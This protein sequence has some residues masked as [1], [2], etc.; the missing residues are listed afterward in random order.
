[1]VRTD[2]AGIELGG[3]QQLSCGVLANVDSPAGCTGNIIGIFLQV[4]IFYN[5]SGF[6]FHVFLV[7]K[8]V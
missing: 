5:L 6:V 7:I 3:A 4:C 2:N 8:E 1:M